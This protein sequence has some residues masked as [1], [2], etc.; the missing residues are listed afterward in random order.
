MKLKT[1]LFIVSS[2]IFLIVSAIFWVYSKYLTDTINEAWGERF[3]HKQIVF[4]KYRTLTPIIREIKVVQKMVNEPDLIA[5]AMDENDPIKRQKGLAVLERYR[6]MFED[7]SYFAA[8]SNTG[9]YYFNDKLNTY[10]TRPLQYTLSPQNDNDRW[11]YTTLKTID[12][13]GVNVDKDKVLGVT[14]VWLNGLI[15]NGDKTIGVVGTGFDFDQFVS[16]S[17]GLEQDGVRNY[18]VDQQLAIQLAKDVTSIDYA[19]IT[20]QNE[21]HKTIQHIFDNPQDVKNV[22]ASMNDVLHARRSDVIETLWC[23]IDGKQQL[24]GIAYLDEIGWFSITIIDPE[25]LLIIN[26]VYIF[27]FMSLL[28]LVILI[29][30]NRIHDR[31]LLNPLSQLQDLM[32][33]IERGEKG[34][35]LSI[36]G[37]GEIAELSAQFNKM[38]DYVH[39]NNEGLENIISE[40]TAGLVLSE[41]KLNTIL[42][43]VEAFIYIKDISYN[44]TYVNKKT[45]LYFAI[46]RDEIIGNDDYMLF[47]KETADQI[48][49]NDRFV[50]E[51]GKKLTKEEVNTSLNGMITTAFLSTKIPL[52]REDGTIY[53]ICGISTDI[54]ERKRFELEIMES[55]RKF[56]TLFDST[57]D[58][59]MLL[60]EKGFFECNRSTLEMFECPDFETFYTFH[61]AELSPLA[62]PG[63]ADSMVLANEHIANAMKNGSEYFEWVHKRYKSG[64]N[65]YAEVSLSAMQLGDRTVLQ[66]LVRDISQ[67]KEDEAMIHKLAFHDPLTQ[68]CNRRLFD[69]KLQHAIDVCKRNKE[70]SAVFFLDL[71]N[72]KPLNDQYGHDVGD[73]L[74]IETALRIKKSVRESD[75]VARFGGDEFVVLLEKLGEDEPLA[76]ENIR[77]VSEKIRRTLSQPFILSKKDQTIQHRCTVSIGAVLFNAQHSCKEE[78]IKIAD[79]S[80]Y[81][82]KELGKNQITITL[83]TDDFC[84]SQAYLFR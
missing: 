16:E 23:S 76:M 74:L 69:E 18:F 20:K 44:Y 39:S 55:E 70:Y 68:L 79:Q 48:R 81:N 31:F 27:I 36:I 13:I 4:D 15:K 61:P 26:N 49:L 45:A 34:I 43:S 83:L 60:D 3:I 75:T 62:Q 63:G 37:T 17:V 73:L 52:I 5:M 21:E 51:Q 28:L 54:T 14:K 7:R 29:L 22:M 8:F 82:S 35:E 24:V 41:Q 53:G 65:F 46:Q 57:R 32:R 42:D 40:R 47:D 50:L 67:R 1:K 10:Y 84:T 11:F 72:F 77:F 19:S 9:H 25:Q 30:L 33:R 38:I 58:A 71:D 12:S 56:R 6:L 66:A 64:E 2:S 78:I 59:V 80:M